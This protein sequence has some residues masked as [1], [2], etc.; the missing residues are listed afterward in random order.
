MIGEGGSMAASLVGVVLASQKK[1]KLAMYMHT[2]CHL[3]TFWSHLK[4][5]YTSD[6][7]KCFSYKGGQCSIVMCVETFK[8]RAGLGYIDNSFG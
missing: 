8:T 3:A 5:L 6:K 7:M 2:S 1:T 4:Q